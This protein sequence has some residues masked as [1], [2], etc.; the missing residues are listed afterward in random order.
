MRKSRRQARIRA[1]LTSPI[2]NRPPHPFMTPLLADCHLHF[3]GS[4]SPDVV[5]SLSRRAGHPF[6]D[7]AAFAARRD[8]VRDAAG[9]LALFAEVCRLFRSPDDYFAAAARLP[10]SLAEDGLAYAEI[11]VSP[12]ICTRIGL[13]A[14]ACLEAVDAG[15][16]AGKKGADCRILLD[17]VRQWGPE[18]AARVL[19][20][21]ERRPFAR[22]VGFGMGGDEGSFP[23][24]DFAAAYSR[25]RRLGLRTS[26][27]AG[28]W[29]GPESIR[30]ALESLSPDR[31]D[32]GIAAGSDPE[33]LA[34]LRDLGTPLLV[35]PSGN[36]ATGAVA[37]LSVH[38]LPRLLQAGV[39]VALS[40]DDPLLFSTTTAREYAAVARAFRLAPAQMGGI[41]ECGWRAAFGL[42]AAEAEA[43]AR[44]AR[45]AFETLRP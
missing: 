37:S 30:E 14:A 25:A 22:V 43:G 29:R 10:E 38:P 4:L 33:L 12:E 36:A 34:R 17:T 42:T 3:E 44:R 21:H 15:L 6:A 31:I 19:D 7:R 18:A 39:A 8:G 28:E 40:A 41:A 16:R 26:V 11:Y 1:F 13:D 2:Y 35:A 5:E 32:H 24:S 27:H 20:L 9:F 23:A 45:A